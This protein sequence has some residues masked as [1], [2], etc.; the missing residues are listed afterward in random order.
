M[1][2]VFLKFSLIFAPFPHTMYKSEI[3]S[4]SPNPAGRQ[5]RVSARHKLTIAVSV[6][7][8]QG[9]AA[10]AVHG[11]DEP[12]RPAPAEALVVIDSA[13]KEQAVKAWKFV[14]GT[15]RL[16]W[17][18]PAAL[19]APPA[20]VKDKTP[21]AGA[22][23]KLPALPVGPEALE[24]RDEKSTDFVTGITLL[25]PLEHIRSIDYDNDQKTV[26]VRVA[27]GAKPDETAAIKGSTKYRGEN[28]LVL[29]TE[30]DK[31]EQGVAEI[32]L[33]G[34]TP[35]GIRA[36]RFPS[37]RPLP[38]APTGRPA[39]V[40]AQDKEKTVHPVVDLLP[41]Y[42]FPDGSLKPIP[43][44]VFRKTLKVDVGTIKKLRFL[45]NNPKEGR[46]CEVLAKDGE[47]NS[48]MLL[49]VPT[50]DSKPAALE[51]LL[52]KVATGYKL[53]PINVISEVRFDEEK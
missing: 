17:L 13:G 30:I 22:K 9:L 6:I 37:P 21:G 51:G 24:M 28:K 41:L 27:A 2:V 46:E 34:G 33:L 38:A 50:L 40:T 11:A 31:G 15:R 1:P 53:F 52:G 14:L 36:V 39:F 32:K 49:Q 3:I 18:A 29:E 4:A 5:R 12:P 48:L 20:E 44:L 35:K 10:L 43:T 26:T 47:E 16:S 23:A 25:V 19:V 8:V 7:L 42:R 45:A